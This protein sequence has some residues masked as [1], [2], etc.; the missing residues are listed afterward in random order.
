MATKKSSESKKLPASARKLLE[1]I[2]DRRERSRLPESLSELSFNLLSDC[3][4]RQLLARWTNPG[5]RPNYAIPLRRVREVARRLG[6]SECD[7]DELMLARLTELE[8]AGDPTGAWDAVSWTMQ[9]CQRAISPEQQ[10]LLDLL[11][12][13]REGWAP[14]VDLT[15]LSN[16]ARDELIGRLRE[17]L[18]EVGDVLTADLHDEQ[19]TPEE[20]AGMRA[21][22]EAFAKRYRERWLAKAKQASHHGKLRGELPLGRRRQ[23]ANALREARETIKAA[24]ANARLVLD[25]GAK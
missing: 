5:E 11:H 23:V 7:V 8:A 6:A 1:I 13:A 9:L 21:Q 4:D 16:E 14:Q 24:Q 20:L 17:L 19:V 15:Y 10:Y 18:R 2:A 22:R 12:D 25:K 3:T